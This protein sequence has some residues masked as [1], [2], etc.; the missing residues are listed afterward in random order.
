[1]NRKIITKNQKETI[2]LGICIGKSIKEGLVITLTGELGSGK[3]T[4]TKGLGIGLEIEKE[5]NS[6]TFVISK[7]YHGR[8]ELVHIDAYRLEDV[9][10]DLG[11]QDYFD[12]SWVAVI[13]WPQYIET[14]LPKKRIDISIEVIG[15]DQR[16]ITLDAHA[17][18]AEIGQ[19]CL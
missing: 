12:Q 2:D 18:L 6:P 8:L 7:I 3:T 9:D 5:V 15:E 10:Q 14:L 16:L 19:D 17:D 1:M 11:F 4:F 13:E